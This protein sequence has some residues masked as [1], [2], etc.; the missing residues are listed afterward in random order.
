M[1]LQVIK[2]D[3]NQPPELL[4]YDDIGPSWAGMIDAAAIATALDELGPVPEIVVG[5]NS[6]GGDAFEAIAMIDALERHPAKIVT[7]AHGLA[8]SAASYLFNAG[9]VRRISKR[10]ELMI[11]EAWVISIGNKRQLKSML[12][13]LE[14][15]DGTAI[16]EYANKA[17]NKATA[18]EIKQWLEAETW[19]NAETAIARGFADEIIDRKQ[20]VP[21]AKVAQGRYQNTPQ[22]Y[23][24]SRTWEQQLRAIAAM[25]RQTERSHRGRSLSSI[26]AQVRN[27]RHRVA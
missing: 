7:E 14:D 26:A 8:A 10:G 23:L 18:N 12:G 1:P 15:I 3:N 27:I 4:I 21:V 9:D 2:H 5:I 24:D 17:G 19:M 13:A 25:G 6:G 16:L 11:H 20:D 22:Q